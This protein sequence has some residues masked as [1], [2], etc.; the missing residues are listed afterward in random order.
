MLW[1]V[2]HFFLS[3]VEV[4]AVIALILI[5]GLTVAVAV[6]WI[7]S[8]SLGHPEAP[9]EGSDSYDDEIDGSAE[10]PDPDSEAPGCSEYNKY[11]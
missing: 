9:P 6:F 3:F 1:Q 11:N 7:L 5:A 8:R 4:I 10:A 2:F